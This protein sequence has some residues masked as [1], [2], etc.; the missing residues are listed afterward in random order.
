MGGQADGWVVA[1]PAVAGMP[2]RPA[3]G[4]VRLTAFWPFSRKEIQ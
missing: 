2:A 3:P 1:G 4:R